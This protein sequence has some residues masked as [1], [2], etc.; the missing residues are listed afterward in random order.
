MGWLAEKQKNILLGATYAP[1]SIEDFFRRE[2]DLGKIQL[3]NETAE[4]AGSTIQQLA[5]NN[6]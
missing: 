2:Q 6:D 4:L 3:L 1:A 5:D